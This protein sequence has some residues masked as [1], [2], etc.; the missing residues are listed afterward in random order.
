VPLLVPTGRTSTGRPTRRR[1]G[2][3]R[4]GRPGPTASRPR[5]SAE[6]RPAPDHV[7]E[8]CAEACVRP[9]RPSYGRIPSPL[10]SPARRRRPPFRRRPRPGRGRTWRPVRRRPSDDESGDLST[11]GQWNEQRHVRTGVLT[12][13]RGE[14]G[15]NAVGSEEARRSACYGRPRSVRRWPRPASPTSTISTRSTS[16]TRF[17]DRLTRDVWGPRLDARQGGPPR[18]GDAAEGHHDDD[19]VADPEA[20]TAT[21]RRPAGSPSRRTTWPPTPTPS[22]RSSPRRHLKTWRAGRSSTRSTSRRAERVRR[23]R[24]RSRRPTRPPTSTASGAAVPRAR[25]RPGR[26]S[27]PWRAASTPAR[28]GRTTRTR[29]ATRRRSA[30]TTSPRWTA[31]CRFTRGSHAP[32]AALEGAVYPAAGGLPLGT[33]FY[34]TTSAFSVAPGSPFTVTAHAPSG[35]VALSLPSGWTFHRHRSRT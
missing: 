23:A 4:T 22:R 7:A 5:P 35:H 26:R 11:F 33:E 19:A 6:R 27:R 30:V 15:G 20:S 25:A 9:G 21:T 17:S 14:G 31:G 3:R 13:T 32:D 12:I 8:D 29:R 28:A 16:T 2:R 24:R 34:L 1:D 18:T 10:N